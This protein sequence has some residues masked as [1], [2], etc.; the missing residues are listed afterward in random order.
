MGKTEFYQHF[1]QPCVFINPTVNFLPYQDP[2]EE[3]LAALV[4][5]CIILLIVKV[6]HQSFFKKKLVLEYFVFLFAFN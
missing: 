1:S 3:E 4:T 2:V 6:R 5:R